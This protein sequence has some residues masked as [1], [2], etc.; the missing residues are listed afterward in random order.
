MYNVIQES[1]LRSTYCMETARKS[2]HCT[3]RMT[4]HNFS[5]CN[6]WT[7]P[8]AVFLRYI[9]HDRPLAWGLKPHVLY[10][11]PGIA[12]GGGHKKPSTWC[13]GWVGGQWGF[14]GFVTAQE[15][16]PSEQQASVRTLHSIR[17]GRFEPRQLQVQPK[18]GPSH[19]PHI[20]TSQLRNSENS[21]SYYIGA[22]VRLDWMD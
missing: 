20:I 13:G 19:K 5:C 17:S 15:V 8:L 4:L 9:T 22:L 11:W 3:A 1:S 6:L 14:T 18:P 7:A 21:K 16:K 12:L 2:I 10:S